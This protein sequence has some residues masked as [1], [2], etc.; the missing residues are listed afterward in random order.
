MIEPNVLTGIPALILGVMLMWAFRRYVFVLRGSVTQHLG[1]AMFW[2]NVRSSGRS[3]WWD[4][5]GGFDLGN[6]S[7][8][9]W[10]LIGLYVSYHALKALHMLIPETDRGHHNLFT[11]AF[12]PYRMWRRLDDDGHG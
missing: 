6:S 10:N 8:W 11:A 2:V 5:F 1:A 4:L 12:Y 7:N 3:I 9:V